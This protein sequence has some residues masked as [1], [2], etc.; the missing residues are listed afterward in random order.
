MNKLIALLSAVL[1]T[2]GL[3]AATPPTKKPVKRPTLVALPKTPFI[4]RQN[5][6]LS[7]KPGDDFYQYANGEW[8]KKNPIPASKTSWGSFNLLREKS[9]DAMKSLLEDATKTTNK[10]RLYQMMGDFYA[11]GMDSA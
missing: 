6:N 2:A 7:V 5:M 8:L 3:M 4:D 11:S 10:G 9:L 1:L